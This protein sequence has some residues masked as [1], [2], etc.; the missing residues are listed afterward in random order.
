MLYLTASSTMLVSGKG[1]LPE[2]NAME[3]VT[4]IAFVSKDA[5]LPSRLGFPSFEAW[6]VEFLT[7]LPPSACVSFSSE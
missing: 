2:E 1:V 6:L 7:K 4:D 5:D 3:S